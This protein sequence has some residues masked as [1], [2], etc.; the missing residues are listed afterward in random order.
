MPLLALSLTYGSFGDIEE[1]FRLTVRLYEILRGSGHLSAEIQKVLDTLKSLYDGTAALMKYLETHSCTHP[2]NPE[3][4]TIADKIAAELDSCNSLLAK[5]EERAA[6]CTSVLVA[7]WWAWSEA[8]ALASWRAGI[9]EHRT[10]IATYIH[11]LQLILSVEGS[12]QLERVGSQVQYLGSEMERVRSKVLH[13][14]LRIAINTPEAGARYVERGD[15]NLV[16][17]EGMVVIRIDFARAVRAGT[18]FDMSVI[19]RPQ[20]DPSRDMEKCPSCKQRNP[21]ASRNAWIHCSNSQCGRRYQISVTRL[22]EVIQNSDSD[23]E[24]QE[25]HSPEPL[26]EEPQTRVREEREEQE[27]IDSFRLVEIQGVLMHKCPFPGCG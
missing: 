25:I 2:S 12:E 20:L 19:K 10:N 14:M 23:S 4:Q 18:E 8:K 13:E 27:E 22:D 16:H 5:L 3:A 1:T 17:P 11:S 6:S 24:T 15:Y 26:N 7:V 21:P 9:A